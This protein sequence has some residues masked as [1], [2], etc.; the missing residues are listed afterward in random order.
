MGTG[1]ALRNIR[2]IV[3]NDFILMNGDSYFE[4]NLNEINYKLDKPAHIFLVKNKNYKSNQKLTN[5]SCDKK[6]V[7]FL[8][9][10]KIIT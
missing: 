3:K 6:N 8:S 10:K 2:E 7:I 5:L 4:I 1:G 9:K